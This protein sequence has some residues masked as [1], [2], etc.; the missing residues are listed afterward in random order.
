MPH[1]NVSENKRITVLLCA[2]CQRLTDGWEDF[3]E[4]ETRKDE[5]DL[6]GLLT[7]HLRR[8]S[9]ATPLAPDETTLAQLLHRPHRR[10]VVADVMDI[11][12]KLRLGRHLWML[13]EEIVVLA[14][15]D[16]P[17]PSICH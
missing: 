12:R 7:R 1:I 14:C 10:D 13:C 11:R 15:P 5:S 6:T 2:P 9:S 3:T 4:R 16:D 17:T 8:K